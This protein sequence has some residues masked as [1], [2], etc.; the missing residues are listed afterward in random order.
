MNNKNSNSNQPKKK[1]RKFEDF[2]ALTVAIIAVT[3]AISSL[4]GNNAEQDV[5]VHRSPAN[6]QWAYY[7]SKSIKSYLHELHKNDL[8]F[9]ATQ[10]KDSALKSMCVAKIVEYKSNIV[11]YDAEKDTI[12][13]DALDHEKKNRTCREER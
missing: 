1:E 4:G 8:E 12:R 5:I 6:D 9:L 11:C 3:L 7:Q 2:V 10:A 13:Q